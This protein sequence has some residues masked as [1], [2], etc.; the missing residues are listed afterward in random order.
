MALA[1]D[2]QSTSFFKSRKE[3]FY[4]F[5]IVA[6]IVAG[7]CLGL[8][9]TSDPKASWHPARPHLWIATI[10]CT[11]LALMVG[12]YYYKT[13]IVK[14][15]GKNGF[16]DT[17]QKPK[18][19][20]IDTRTDSET[21]ATGSNA[22][23]GAESQEPPKAPWLN[24]I[25][26]FGPQKWLNYIALAFALLCWA[27]CILVV[28]FMS[29]HVVGGDNSQMHAAVNALLLLL[30]TFGGVSMGLAIDWNNTPIWYRHDN[31]ASKQP[32]TTT[33]SSSSS[34]ASEDS[35]VA[36]AW[37]RANEG[38]VKNLDGT[39][40]DRTRGSF[41]KRRLIVLERLLQTISS[42]HGRKRNRR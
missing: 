16:V 9:I 33:S 13:C 26:E 19:P 2:H 12:C 15:K 35:A 8:F 18:T 24:K 42:D 22:N 20:S 29:D 5:G 32:E 14:R 21:S 6:F 17:H 7:I 10:C 30:A 31:L 3:F 36:R 25:L 39:Y 23:T 28:V 34:N 27:G 40:T 38:F 1:E 41:P 37:D 11:A 4:T